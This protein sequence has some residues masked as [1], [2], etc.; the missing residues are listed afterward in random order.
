[1]FIREYEYSNMSMC[2]SDT[3]QEAREDMRS[4]GIHINEIPLGHMS[5]SDSLVL[6]RFTRPCS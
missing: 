6:C 2:I 4:S 3:L 1:M 5:Q